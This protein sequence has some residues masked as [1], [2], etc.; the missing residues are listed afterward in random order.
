MGSS[1][2]RSRLTAIQN[3]L[4]EAVFGRNRTCFLSGG[5]ALAGFHLK[6]RATRDLDLFLLPEHSLEELVLDVKVA[7][8][9]IGATFTVD[10]ESS[11]FRRL[12]VARAGEMTL[13]DLVT[14]LDPQVAGPKVAFGSVLVDPLREI[15]AN[16]ICAVLD[17]SEIRDVFDLREILRSGLTLP[18]IVRDAQKKHAGA[19]P[20]SIACSL[21]QHPIIAG[22]SGIKGA[23]TEEIAEFRDQLIADLLRLA[24]PQ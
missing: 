21:S 6:H 23:G 12:A 13:V 14:D 16:K 11:A 10:R 4:L 3:E 7:V 17:R 1:S 19:D 22:V 9:D 24:T 15:A 20:G 18:E 5:A 8:R 2:G